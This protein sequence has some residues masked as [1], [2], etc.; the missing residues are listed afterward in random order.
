MDL[1]NKRV[2]VVGLGVSGISA[3]R[4]LVRK[5]ADVKA[6]DSSGE[7]GIGEEARELES[8]GVTLELAGHTES[9]C[10][11]ADLVVTSPGVPDNALPL[12]YARDNAIPVI[13]ELELAYRFCPCPLIAVT[14]TNGKST[15]TELI[16]TILSRS[17]KHT[18]VC[19]NIGTPLTSLLEELT[20]ESVAVAEVSSFQLDRTE[21]FKPCI[22]V[23]LNI[24]EDHYE[25]H[26]D[27][28]GYRSSKLRIFSN[29]DQKDWALVHSSLYGEKDLDK[30]GVNKIFYGMDMG[31]IIVRSGNICLISGGEARSLL[32]VSDLP[33]EGVHNIE[34]V[35]CALLVSRIMGVDPG[36]AAASVKSFS[37]LSHRFQ[38]IGSFRGIEF[39]DDSKATNVDAV[40]RALESI[41][42]K[43]VLIAGGIDKGGDYSVIS[44]LVREKVKAMVLIGEA[45]DMI[46]DLFRDDIRVERAPDMREAV[47]KAADLAE[48]GEAVLLSPMC[49]SFDMFASYKERGEEF[50]KAVKDIAEGDHR[51][52]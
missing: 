27:M 15:T 51:H 44:E 30:S 33:V 3:A 39:I 5:G 17:G 28:A 40:R 19:G 42:R 6:T 43:A 16:G 9:F 38:R 32:E 29:Q 37:G 26:G 20:P 36:E 52:R 46:A 10:E 21:K 48:E 13:G 41:E 31:P 7:N 49:S 1:K 23:L 12:A 2:L 8:S 35:I 47:I 50:Q 34:N 22:S 14:G 25:R 4:F 24:A 18:A 11:G 45:A